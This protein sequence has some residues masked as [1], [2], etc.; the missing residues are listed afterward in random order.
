MIS[1]DD[2]FELLVGRHNAD[3]MLTVNSALS[4]LNSPSNSLISER[5]I[6][7]QFDSH[8]EYLGLSHGGVLSGR[9]SR[10]HLEEGEW[11]EGDCED[12]DR[13]RGGGYPKFNSPWGNSGSV[14]R[15]R[16]KIPS[17]ALN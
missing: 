17:R 9:R 10:S 11:V 14:R 13:P 8:P 1:I 3:S 12:D 15:R 6:S 7:R 5:V 2:D 4:F 16:E